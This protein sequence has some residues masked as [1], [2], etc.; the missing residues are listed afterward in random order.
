VS[1]VNINEVPIKSRSRAEVGGSGHTAVMAT[2]MRAACWARTP[3]PTL[4]CFL[5]NCEM[6]YLE[7]KADSSIGIA[8]VLEGRGIG[9]RLPTGERD[10]SVRNI[11]QTCSGA[12]PACPLSNGESSLSVKLD[13][14]LT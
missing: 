2:S 6:H 11:F 10:F 3:V 1:I 8:T 5:L 12:L 14:P 13:A 4:L 7:M 9:D